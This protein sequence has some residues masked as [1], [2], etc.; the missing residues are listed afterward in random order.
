MTGGLAMARRVAVL[1]GAGGI[2]R[3]LVAR[4]LAEGAAVAVLDLPASLER[5]P[6]P[7][8]AAAIPLDLANVA[9]TAAAFARLAGLF[10]AL[11]GFVNLAGFASP[12]APLEGVSPE[13]FDEV[14]AGNL[15]GTLLA[16]QHVLPLLAR[17]EGGSL[18]HTASGLAQNIRPGYGPYAIA[19][20]GIIA[21][22]RTLALEAAPR[23]RVN[24]VCPGAVDT[25][26]LRG[27]TGRSDEANAPVLDLS[28]YVAAIPLGRLAEPEDIVGPILFLLSDAS[29]YMT[30]QCLWINGGG[31]MP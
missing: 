14:M 17:G 12:R 16:A 27:G 10:P 24:A 26:F 4:L 21:M 28:A 11:D 13:L 20:A 6:A 18:V 1:G 2:G 30:G 7:A 3:A 29:R 19:K 15:R 23:V 25:A 9:G 8:E 22:T 5:Y 31:Y